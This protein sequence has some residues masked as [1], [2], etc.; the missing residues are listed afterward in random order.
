LTGLDVAAVQR[1]LKRNLI[2]E[3]DV[4]GSLQAPLSHT[5]AGAAARYFVIHDTSSPNFR[6][7]S[8]PANIDLD[9]WPG[10]HL[11]RY[12]T[13]TAGPHVFVNRVGGSVTANPFEVASLGTKFEKLDPDKRRGLFI[14]VELIQPRRSD[15]HRRGR[16]DGLAPEPGFSHSQLKRL[17]LLYIVASGRSGRWLIPAYHAVLDT[18]IR[19]GHDDPQHF[20]L[21]RWAAAVHDV[22]GEIRSPR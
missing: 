11:G 17:A 20:D 12:R 21:E 10:N 18:D 14:H 6:R 3:E 8:F 22:L 4:G 9:S 19:N 1:Y 7:H 13:N 2:A 16:N 15:P 5:E